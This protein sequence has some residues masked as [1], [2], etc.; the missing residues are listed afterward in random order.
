MSTQ[1]WQL[2]IIKFYALRSQQI[3]NPENAGYF[4]AN[5]YCV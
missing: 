3:H 5:M 1:Y 4:Y 2:F